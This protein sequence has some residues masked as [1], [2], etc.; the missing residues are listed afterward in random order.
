MQKYRAALIGCSRIGGFI[1]N[2]IPPSEQ[3][4]YPLPYSHAAC[5]EACE[6]TDLVACSDL[7]QDIMAQF[8]RCYRIPEQRQYADFRELI[9]TEKPDIL[10][11]ATQPE[12]R[13]EIII[14]AVEN[15]V[16]AIW[17]EKALCAS[18]ED[19]DAVVEAVERNGAVLNMHTQKR[20]DP[21][22]ATAKD[23]IDSG[24]LGALKTMIIYNN[25][26]LWDGSSHYFDVVKC[27]ND[28]SPV[29]WI[30][31]HLP[32]GSS[33]FVHGTDY[34]EFEG[35]IVPGDPSAHGII[36][37]QNG[38]V[39]YA[40][41]SGRGQD[42]DLVCERGTISAIDAGRLWQLRRL[43]PPD[44][45][46]SEN[47]E[48]VPFPDFERRSLSLGLLEDLV[49]SLD[50]GNPPKGGVRLARDIT[51]MILAFIVSHQRGGAK[52]ELPLVD[53]KLR[54]RRLKPPKRPR[55]ERRYPRLSTKGEK[56]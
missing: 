54:H 38:V 20:F 24:E 9:D 12:E 35:N 5:Y 41:L 55:Y 18:L 39:A 34:D 36:Q 4:A 29:A 11:A 2:E 48:F 1:D 3:I 44:E 47:I 17:A 32:G 7:R 23:L 40:L 26:A 50:S 28:D 22:F 16:K 30:Q 33:G 15:G 51:E 25:Y 43:Q 21:G 53:I 46:G 45:Y 42:Y 19:A 27:L 14:Y 37:F 31:G 10:S 6:R 13:A 52:V 8:G 56:H 49:H